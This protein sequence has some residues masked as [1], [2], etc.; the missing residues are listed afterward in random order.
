MLVSDCF[1]TLNTKSSLVV[2]TNLPN[3]RLPA[4]H[5]P[6][7]IL[8]KDNYMIYMASGFFTDPII[9]WSS[10]CSTPT[11]SLH[12]QPPA[13]PVRVKIKQTPTRN[14]WDLVQD[15]LGKTT[16]AVSDNDLLH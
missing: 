1:N 16:L 10:F 4:L 2:R 8:N 15:K 3:Y 9:P 11:P 14:V 6:I 13:Q 7:W 12:P 5:D